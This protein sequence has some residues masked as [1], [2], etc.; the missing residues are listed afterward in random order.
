MLV[1]G[2]ALVGASVSGPAEEGRSSLAV[3]FDAVHERIAEELLDRVLVCGVT[4][5]IEK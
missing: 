2:A 4:S 1:A 5:L 3:P